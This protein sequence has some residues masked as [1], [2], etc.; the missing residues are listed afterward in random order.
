MGRVDGN[1]NL[2]RAI[3]DFEYK[4]NL[5]LKPEEQK[6]S[7]FPD[8]LEFEITNKDEFIIVG[9][10]GIWDGRSNQE[11]VDEVREKILNK[12]LSLN[13]T[14]ESLLDD[15]LAKDTSGTFFKG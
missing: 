2:T 14:A 1:L 13:E 8:I 6:I 11:N 10:D 7:A 12:K 3:G 9:C 5:A 15:L 4:G